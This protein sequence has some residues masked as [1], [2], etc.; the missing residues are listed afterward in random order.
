[1]SKYC[2]K[3]GNEI[4][5]GQKFCSNCGNNDEPVKTTKSKKE[6]TNSGL[7]IAAFVVSLVSLLTCGTIS[8]V[9]LILSIVG[10]AT[11]KKKN[12][13]PG[14]AIA[15]LV[16]SIIQLIFFILAIVI[17]VTDDPVI[18]EDYSSRQYSEMVE[19]CKDSSHKCIVKE[20]YS[21]DVENGL[22]IRQE[23]EA[24]K[25][26]YSFT[27]ATIYYSKG[28]KP[29]ETTTTKQE[30]KKEAGGQTSTTTTTTTTK[31]PA[32]E[33]QEYKNKCQTYKYKDIARNPNSYMYK[34][35]KFTGKV[36]QTLYDGGYAYFRVN[37]TKDKYG[38]Y[39]DTIWVEYKPEKSESKFLEDDIVNIW[40]TLTGEYSYESVLGAQITIPSIKAKYMELK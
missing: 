17:I 21:D 27:D 18:T 14:L 32:M 37:V 28:K 11:S 6:K 30:E 34:D 31:S 9:S 5:T 24:G 8:L 12:A 15:G 3:C 16:L 38:F 20:E 26:R 25:E 33:K 23:P 1:M 29:V 39:E 2:S 13:K 22:F 40:G 35:A 36:V 4:T 7:N 19:Y 10:L